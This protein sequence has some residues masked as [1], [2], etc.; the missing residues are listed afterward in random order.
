MKLNGIEII[1]QQVNM[2]QVDGVFIIHN[3]ASKKVIQ[4][5][6][7]SSY[8]WKI[9]LEYEKVGD[10]LDT[11]HIFHKI[12]EA[13]VIQEDMK[14]DV[15]QDIEKILQDFFDSGLLQKQSV[16]HT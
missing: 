1:L 9:I 3:P 7:T 10:D 16:F 12:L 2:E 14:Q 5:N 13:F 4:F 11:S 6:E 15:C 8:V